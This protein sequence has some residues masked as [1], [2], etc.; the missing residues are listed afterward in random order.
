MYCPY[1]SSVLT[2]RN[3]IKNG[4]H[5]SLLSHS[6]SFSKYDPPFLG[7]WDL[8]EQTHM[9]HLFLP[10]LHHWTHSP[11]V[12]FIYNDFVNSVTER[13]PLS[14][15]AAI[16]SVTQPNPIKW[17]LMNFKQVLSPSST[18]AMLHSP[19]APSMRG[20]TLSAL[21]LFT[22]FLPLW[23]AEAPPVAYA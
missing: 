16:Q 19:L 2:G 1:C 3:V 17:L 10:L 21:L 6:Y 13:S 23:H 4:L 9:H 14:H 7:K 12:S 11:C 5:L 8:E 20:P 15:H 18:C 22:L